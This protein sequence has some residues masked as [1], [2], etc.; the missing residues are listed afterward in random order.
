M[1]ADIC[2]AYTTLPTIV[3]AAQLTD[4]SVEEILRWTNG[5]RLGPDRWIPHE[6]CWRVSAQ[7]WYP[8]HDVP[9]GPA[10]FVC[11][12]H[13]CGALLI[14]IRTRDGEQIAYENDWLVQGGGGAFSIV[15][16]DQ[17]IKLY[18]RHDDA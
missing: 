8:P 16:P 2:T 11:W 10:Q 18:R 3:H 9:G 4:N 1:P 14:G 12:L 13:R 15:R 6:G 5:Y 17:F 7:R